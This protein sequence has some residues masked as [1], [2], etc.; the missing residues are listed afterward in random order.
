MSKTYIVDGNSLLFRAYYSTAYTGNIMTT[1][2][3]LPINA[4]FAFHNL[5]KKIKAMVNDGDHLYVTFDTGKPTFRKKEFE[6]YKAQRSPAPQELVCQMPIAREML[7]AM[8]ICWNEMEGYEGDDLAG[9]MAKYASDKGDDVRLFTSDKDFLQLLDF[10]DHVTVEMLKKGLSETICYT[11]N[12]LKELFGLNPDQIVDFKG[13]AGDSSDNYKGIKGIGEKTAMKLLSE[14]GHLEQILEYCKANPNNKTNQKIIAGEEDA[15][16]FKSLANIYTDLDMKEEYDKSLY[17]H[18]QKSKLSAFYLKYSLSQFL[19]GIDRLPGLNDD[20]NHQISLFGDMMHADEEKNKQD[21]NQ[22]ENRTTIKISSFSEIKDKVLSFYFD[23]LGENENTSTLYEFIFGT[24]EHLYTL[25]LEDAKKDESFTAFLKDEN[26]DIAVYDQ[27]GI[28]VLLNRYGFVPLS[29]V[30]FDLLIATYLINP[31]SGQKKEELFL[32]YGVSFESDRTIAEQICSYIIDLRK[33]VEDE[34]KKNDEVKLF[35]EV[36]MPLSRILAN[37]EIEGFPIDLPTLKE[38]DAEYQG[39]LKSLQD[40]IYSLAGKEFN[41]NSPK[42]LDQILF[43]DLGIQRNKGE[44]GTGIEVLT[45]HQDEHPIIPL[46]ISY[47]L[48]NKLVSGYT[49]ALPNHVGKDGKIHA[50]YNQAL[51]ATGRLSMSE[52]NLQNISIRN[53]EGKNIRKAFFYPNKEFY[54]LSLDYSQVE[55]RML[56]HVA[57]IKALKEIFKEGKDIHRA[58]ASKVFNVPFDEVSDEMRRRAKAVNFGIVYGI[59]AFGLSN[60]LD[61]PTSEASML[62]NQFK[63]AFD[64]IDKFQK[65]CVENAREHGYVSTILNRRRYLKDINSSNRA[66]RAFSERAATNT[67]IQGSAADLIKVAMIACDKA[68]KGYKSKIILQIHDELLF[69]VP[70]DEIDKVLPL[71]TEAMD[72]ALELS[73]PLLVDGNAAE[74]WYE[75]H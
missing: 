5:I 57:D 52:P 72:H 20:T 23:A 51:T 37:M 67:V 22:F 46:I 43:T 21:E 47:R 41:I 28:L 8:D 38:I 73:V 48:Y 64:G 17:H 25:S 3:G 24:K 56:A 33:T 44:K 53:E 26:K 75:A 45:A 42:Q 69:K 60:Q 31:D 13:I 39:I 18:Y 71:L 50:I 6:N 55:L 68:L 49:Q 4:I 74:T 9:S 54:I 30:G 34:L 27:K 19:K 36:E 65:E 40:K 7:D 12:N 1:K 61:I 15:L 58:T 35:K 70:K 10:S 32:S 11:K 62:I 2:S 14:Y 16:F 59:S 63:T 29:G 66:L